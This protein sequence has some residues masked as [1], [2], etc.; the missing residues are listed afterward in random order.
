MWETFSIPSAFKRHNASHAKLKD[1]GCNIR[2]KAYAYK[3][4]LKI[5]KERQHN[6]LLYSAYSMLNK[7]I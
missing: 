4:N 3:Q 5:Q 2:E 7:N 6:T 1:F